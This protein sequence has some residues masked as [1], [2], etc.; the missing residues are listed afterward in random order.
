[1]PAR[2]SSPRDILALAGFLAMC[3]AVAAMGSLATASSVSTWYVTLAKPVWTPPAWVFAPVWTTLYA[4]MAVAAWL[5]W[6]RPDALRGSALVLFLVQLTLNG[7]WSWF[8]FGFRQIGLALLDIGALFVALAATTL[9]FRRVTSVA[10]WLML[11]YLLWVTYAA[12][13]NAAIWRLNP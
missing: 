7:A 4:A 9:V 12:S 2:P 10:A 1:M 5:V 13:L 6:R 3:F 11:P 8:F